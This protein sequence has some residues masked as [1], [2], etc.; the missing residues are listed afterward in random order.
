MIVSLVL[1]GTESGLTDEGRGAKTLMGGVRKFPIFWV[2][3]AFFCLPAAHAYPIIFATG[4][5]MEI[6]GLNSS[7]TAETVDV[8]ASF[9]FD[10]T[11]QQITISLLN[12]LSRDSISI[13]NIV[14]A[15]GA[16]QFTLGSVGSGVT[17]GQ[18][19]VSVTPESGASYI[20]ISTS[21]SSIQSSPGNWGATKLAV[22]S[23][24]GTS[25]TA[26]GAIGA[27][28]YEL[29]VICDSRDATGAT[30]SPKGMLIS[31][32][33]NNTTGAYSGTGSSLNNAHM[34]FLLASGDTY[35]SGPLSTAGSVPTWVL[36][37]PSN[38]LT[39][40]TTVTSV[41]FFFGSAAYE[42]ETVDNTGITPEPA[43]SLL[44][45]SGLALAA[46]CGRK[47]I[48]RKPEPAPGKII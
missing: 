4:P 45:L 33:T 41:T 18:Q 5:V 8:N 1:K 22:A 47:R 26:L 15:I 13:D 14:Q 9:T 29:C 24:S 40:T 23:A 21:A 38:S 35:S 6:P 12:L 31:G 39:A 19:A 32:P 46:W 30:G 43:T 11:N 37:L 7:G 3:A 36:T 10:S 48:V 16:I 20:N 2:L 44:M 17:S 25:P 27:N 34:P 28:T 42:W